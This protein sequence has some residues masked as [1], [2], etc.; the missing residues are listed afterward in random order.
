MNVS[1]GEESTLNVHNQNF[2]YI[3]PLKLVKITTITPLNYA[4]EYIPECIVHLKKGILRSHK[5]EGR[6][7]LK[8]IG[9]KRGRK[10]NF[11]NH[12]QRLPAKFILK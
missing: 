1:Q 4:S 9:L 10:E 11:G 6:G 7:W 8:K 2:M 5:S 12:K 3:V